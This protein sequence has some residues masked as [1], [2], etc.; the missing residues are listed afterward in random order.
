M[1]GRWTLVLI[2]CFLAWTCMSGCPSDD[3]D[4]GGGDDDTGDDDTG[5][6]DTGDDDTGDDDTGDDDDSASDDDSTGDDD[7][8]TSDDDDVT[9]DDDD[10]TSDD[11]DVTSD[12]DDVTSDDD[13]D[14]TTSPVVQLLE[15]H[16][17]NQT[18][19]PVGYRHF[20]LTGS[21]I[22]LADAPAVVSTALPG[23][24]VD[25]CAPQSTFLDFHYCYAAPGDF[26]GA[27]LVDGRTGGLV[28]AGEI[29]WMGTGQLLFPTPLSPPTALQ[30]V[31]NPPTIAPMQTE[32]ALGGYE[33]NAVGVAAL[34][35][36]REMDYVKNWV[37]WGMYDALVYLHPYSVGAYNP[38]EADIV[39]ILVLN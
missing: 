17:E 37:A 30:A 8:V 21:P 9:G 10:V 4:F 7:D 38:A 6:D 27:A 19:A 24:L 34:D 12:D 22:P 29:I 3:D 26:G 14:A 32:L 23:S 11:D 13:D 18:Y 39:V 28:F 31:V 1:N 36:V 5:D 33:V 2:A 25:G 16:L 20:A 15:I 35:A